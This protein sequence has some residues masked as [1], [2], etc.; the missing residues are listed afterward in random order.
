MNDKESR[1]LIFELNGESYAL[2]LQD[3]EEIMELPEIYPLPK[4]PPYYSGIINCHGTPMPVLD[5]AAFFK[6]SPARPGNKILILDR[7]IANLAVRVH[8]VNGIVSGAGATNA[9]SGNAD[10]IE[11]ALVVAGREIK[12]LSSEK[13]LLLLEKE[14][15]AI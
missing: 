12:L 5:L 1:F 11:E 6:K 3:I 2:T 4:A 14:A 10:E 15:N 8:A 9:G 13:L 7:K